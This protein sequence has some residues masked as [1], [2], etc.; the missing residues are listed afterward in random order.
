MNNKRIRQRFDPM[1][2][3]V[4]QIAREKKAI[5]IIIMG[6]PLWN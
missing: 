2:F 6:F 1:T 4:R 5:E 3:W